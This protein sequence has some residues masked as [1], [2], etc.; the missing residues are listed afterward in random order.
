MLDR[1]IFSWHWESNAEGGLI[2]LSISTKYCPT[3]LTEYLGIIPLDVAP[4]QRTI[5]TAN[6]E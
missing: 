3:L 1:V 4:G 6:R 2:W 5:L